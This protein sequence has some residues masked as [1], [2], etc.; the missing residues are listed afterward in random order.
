M[1]GYLKLAQQLLVEIGA[2]VE[3]V[4]MSSINFIWFGAEGVHA[5]SQ[6]KQQT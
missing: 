1:P 4:E 3:I 6:L 5:R 2:I